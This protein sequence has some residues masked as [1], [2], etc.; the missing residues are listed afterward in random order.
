MNIKRRNFF[1]GCAAASACALLPAGIAS[2][3]AGTHTN[4]APVTRTNIEKSIKA[5][6]GGGFSLQ[7]HSQA[8]GYIY[9]NIEHLGTRYAVAS[10]D[11][12]DWKIV[13]SL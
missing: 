6:F 7:G 5:G 10:A 8:N 12:L 9:A 2:A 4:N 3:A 1:K 13:D 11:L